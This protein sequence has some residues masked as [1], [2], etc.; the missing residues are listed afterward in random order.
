MFIILAIEVLEWNDFN[1]QTIK[2]ESMKKVTLSNQINN[3]SK[4]HN[5]RIYKD[6][7]CLSISD[8]W[9]PRSQNTSFLFATSIRPI[10]NPTVGTIRS[11]GR[12]S[13]FVYTDFIFSSKV[14]TIIHNI[15][16]IKQL[17]AT[18]QSSVVS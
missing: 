18:R 15:A 10:F 11:G 7:Y 9:P 17:R 3:S 5:Y 12:P 13:T 4:Y 8:T 16:I 2:P 14:Y 6:K 1:K